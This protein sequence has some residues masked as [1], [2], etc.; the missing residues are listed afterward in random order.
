[1]QCPVCNT[2][3]SDK[4]KKQ[5]NHLRT[6]STDTLIQEVLW[7]QHL[8]TMYQEQARSEP[9]TIPQADPDPVG[10]L[11]SI[12]EDEANEEETDEAMAS[13]GMDQCAH[14]GLWVWPSDMQ[15]HLAVA[16]AELWG[17]PPVSMHYVE[18]DDP[19]ALP[20]DDPNRPPS[21]GVQ[22]IR[23]AV[24]GPEFQ[25]LNT[26]AQ[27][28]MAARNVPN[29]PDMPYTLARYGNHITMP[30]E[31]IDAQLLNALAWY[32]RRSMGNE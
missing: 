23:I 17:D 30:N 8:L 10:M 24:D 14:C 16:C 18:Q 32:V 21:P 13:A 11:T 9:P 29:G 15:Y 4:R 25:V 12:E 6:H 2:T 28:I 20:T 7:L 31:D 3:I 26:F 27:W 22:A 1:M 5:I 19:L